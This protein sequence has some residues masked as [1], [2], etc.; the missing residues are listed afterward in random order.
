MNKRAIIYTR[1]SPRKNAEECESCETQQAYCEQQAHNKKYEIGLVIK[2]ADVSGADEYRP[3]LWA[4][5]EALRRGDILIVY[6]RDR[7]A[8]NVYLSEQINRAVASRGATIEAVS[9]DVDGD[10]P[11][12]VMIRQVLSSI[13]EYERKLIADR[14]SHAMRM[15][16]SNGRRMGR[17]APYGWSIDPE[18][19]K[20]L[21]VHPVEQAAVGIIRQMAGEGVGMSVI[22]KSLNANMPQ[23][24]RFGKWTHVTVRKIARRTASC[25]G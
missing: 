21:V 19:A 12:H 14:T 23:A 24:A 5:I 11:E 4:A 16:Q 22:A 17:Y 6:K 7:L 15:H 20:R 8:R 10:G 3:K 9:G 2:D 1:F 18:D 25:P 13:A